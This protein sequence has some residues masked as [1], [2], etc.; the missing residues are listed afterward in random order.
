[1]DF[2][3]SMIHEEQ[4]DVNTKLDSLQNQIQTFVLDD[5]GTKR[6]DIDKD[7]MEF[8]PLENLEELE[9]LEQLLIDNKINRK[10][11]LCAYIYIYTYI[12]IYIFKI[13]IIYNKVK[14]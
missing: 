13:I 12:Y 3:M 2:K 8:F 1:M 9:N 5:A 10:A 14:N 6:K 4:K 7:Y 11:F